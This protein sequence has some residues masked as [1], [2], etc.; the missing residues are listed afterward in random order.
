[1]P[2]SA[3]KQSCVSRPCLIAIEAPIRCLDLASGKFSCRCLGLIKSPYCRLTKMCYY[4]CYIKDCTMKIFN[5]LS[6]CQ[7]YW[8]YLSLYL[9]I[10]KSTAASET[11]LFKRSLAA[12]ELSL[13]QFPRL[14]APIRYDFLKF[15]DLSFFLLLTL[16]F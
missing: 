13:T 7:F 1:M 2:I 9:I 16:H 15:I 11:R 14:R 10:G 3:V 6:V 12:D 8:T 5:T 4:A